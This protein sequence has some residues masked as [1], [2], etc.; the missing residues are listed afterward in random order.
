MATRESAPHADIES[1]EARTQELGRV[2]LAEMRRIRP[3]PSERLQDWLLT[4]AVG[5]E[6]FRTRTLRFLDVLAAFDGPGHADDI[7]GL[8]RE[9]FADEFPGIPR[10][11]RWL[12]AAGSH[13]RVPAPVVAAAARQGTRTFA[14]RFITE[15][16]DAGVHRLVDR[17]V[18]HDRVPS[19]DLLG[20]AVLSASE[21]E[22][23]EARYL[24]LIEDLARDVHAHGRTVGDQPVLQVSIKLSSLTPHFTPVDPDGSVERVLAPLT[25]IAEAARAAGVGLAVDAEQFALREIVWEAFRRAF[26]PDGPLGDWTDAGIVVQSYLRDVSAHLDDVLAF[27]ERRGVPFHVRLVK[28]A[29]WD[30]EVAVASAN[31]WPAPVFQQ[32][33]STDASMERC[34]DRLVASLDRVHLA[35][36][37][38]NP[39]THAYARAVAESHGL[40]RGAIEH[41]TLHRTSEAMSRALASQGWPSRDYV[42]VGDLLP[43]MAYLVRRILENSS[44]AGFLM[45]SRL[46]DAPEQLLAPPPAL[47][48]PERVEPDGAPFERAPAAR[49]F[50]PAFRTAFDAALAA[51]EE[52]PRP[53]LELPEGIDPEDVVEIRSPSDPDGKPIGTVV[54]ATAEGATVAIERAVEAQ[55]AWAARPVEERA[56]VLRRAA[57]LLL[58]RGHEFAVDVVREGGRD[59]A[60]AWAEMDEA[61]DFLRMYAAEAERL[62][63]SDGSLRP[64]GVVAVIPPWNFSLAIPCGMTVAALVSGNA[65]I[66]KPAGQTPLVAGRLVAL[67]HEAGVPADVLQCLPGAGDR[68]GRALV[69][70]PRVAMV[71]FTGSRSV[72]TWMHETIARHPCTTGRP[73]ALVAEMGGKNPAIVFADAD[74]DEAVE[75]VLHSAFDHANQKCSAVSRVLVERAMFERFRDRIVE[76]AAALA[77]GPAEDPATQVNPVIDRR[78]SER[79][80]EEARVARTEGRVLLDRFEAPEG[81][82]Q[83]GPLI[84]EVD[85]ARALTA[86]VA[87]EELFG[88]ILALIPF[89][90]EAEAYRIANGTAYA[91]TSA[92]FSRSPSRIRRAAAAIE[93]GHVYVNRTSTAARPGVEPFGGMRFSGTGPKAGST[94]YLA[95]FMEHDDLPAETPEA[96]PVAPTD[97]VPAL[98]PTRWEAPLIER[99]AAVRRAASALRSPELAAAAEAAWELGR[100][101]TVQVAGQHTWTVH[102]TPRGLGLVRAGGAEAAWWLAAPLLAG[103]AVIVVDSPDLKPVVRAL[104]AAGVPASALRVEDGGLD[105]V[106]LAASTAVG[107]VATD[108][109]PFAPLAAALGPA[110]EAHCGLRALISPLDGPR[111][112]A[113]GFLRRFAWPKVVAVRTLRH[114]ATL[115]FTDTTADH[116]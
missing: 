26:G 57:D 54:T 66:L 44:Q 78:A 7:A 63:A 111:P 60:G 75:G 69:E 51:A 46:Q 50:D 47:D 94:A 106:T 34:I 6:R 39:R 107:F 18:Q 15:P 12:V 21:A 113:A 85:P 8:F 27:A 9:Y 1:I 89:D 22:A 3:H 56:D 88:P 20:E 95:A 65:V 90:D 23:Y 58:E 13:P 70:D 114:G 100:E 98:E 52:A 103:N 67:L 87:T 59:R 38:H 62:A 17:L 61:V 73:R 112:G 37:S 84:V 35:V 102:D 96:D 29:Y 43:G 55:P 25:R 68:A 104:H 108:R 93:A 24:A 116:A 110:G 53:H 48:D 97:A 45:Q 41:Q 64:R 16:G 10:P 81:T 72:G 11:L 77:C 19:F 42:P 5:D 82:L 40:R 4:H 101:P 79:L 14:R 71:A 36:A 33:A 28:G 32:K 74:L 115:E 86:R 80:A 99:V 91:L 109:G 30:Y 83:H 105:L 76:A 49:W 2:L 31:R 92:V